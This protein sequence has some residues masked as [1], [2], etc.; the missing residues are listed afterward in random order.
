M[1]RSFIITLSVIFLVSACASMR[2]LTDEVIKARNTGKEGVTKVYPVTKNQAWDIT[3]T[4]LCWEKTDEIEEHKDENYVIA[5]TGMKM[6]V[7]GS[8]MGVWIE[9]VDSGHTMITVL[10]RRR[11]RN[12]TF[13]RLTAFK[14]YERFD[15][16]VKIVKSGKK[17]PV[18]PPLK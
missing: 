2:E 14:F 12:D 11:V 10:T 13:T 18:I 3:K 4:V 5:G 7:F 8:V 9:S 1:R 17:L 6:A 16:G 15:Q